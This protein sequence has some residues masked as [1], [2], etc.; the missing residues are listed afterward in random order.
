MR[1]YKEL[2]IGTQTTDFM[3]SEGIERLQAIINELQKN[4]FLFIKNSQKVKSP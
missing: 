1:F 4:D 3:R 2:N